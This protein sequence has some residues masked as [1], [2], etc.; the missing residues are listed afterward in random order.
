MSAD[1]RRQAGFQLVSACEQLLD[2]SGPTALSQVTGRSKSWWSKLQSGKDAAFPTWETLRRILPASVSEQVLEQLQAE[3]CA[4]WSHWQGVEL[5]PAANGAPDL[6]AMRHARDGARN[7]YL[8]GRY[9][10]ALRIYRLLIA[11]L[12]ALPE[13]D[14]SDERHVLVADCWSD[15]SSCHVQLGEATAG[16]QAARNAVAAQ[17]RAGTDGVYARH[18]LALAYL[19]AGCLQEAD[20]ELS[21]V[22]GIYQGNGLK[23]EIIRARRDRV[24]V[25]FAEGRYAAATR[26]LRRILSSAMDFEPR[27]RYPTMLKMA[28]SLA[29]QHRAEEARDCLD[30]A[31]VYAERNADELRDHLHRAHAQAH[32]DYLQRAIVSLEAA[33][34]DA[35]PALKPFVWDVKHAE[36]EPA[37]TDYT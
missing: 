4:A 20:K 8:S 37:V 25:L 9:A 33:P 34:P 19:H 11:L 36:P 17:H 35:P 30:R 22:I 29:L 14:G 24:N 7:T 27:F 1:R 23:C 26:A 21:A 18:Q 31:L 32:L 13:A 6:A 12:K 28:E 2:A 15:M 3:W 10:D 5:L 16:V